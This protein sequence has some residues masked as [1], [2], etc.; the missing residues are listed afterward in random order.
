[1]AFGSGAVRLTNQ[2][3]N[4]GFVAR[5]TDAGTTAA[6][7]WAQ[8]VGASGDESVKALALNGS[9]IYVAGGFRSATTT[10]G[11]TVLTNAGAAPTEDIFV[12]KLTDTGPAATVGWAKQ[13]GGTGTDFARAIATDGNA[14]WVVGD[15]SSATATF[16]SIVLTS[17]GSADIFLTRLNDAG[18][19]ATYSWALRAGGQQH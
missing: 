7:D 10:I 2:G 3:L 12:T 18:S 14:L 13:A 17:A 5:L 8:T 19:T 6:F 11:T 16:G 4:D 15:F 9:T 1:M